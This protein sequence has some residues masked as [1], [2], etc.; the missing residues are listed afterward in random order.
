[1]TEHNQLCGNESVTLKFGNRFGMF[2]IDLRVS[3]L[4]WALCS[5]I[6]RSRSQRSTGTG[7]RQLPFAS[8]NIVLFGAYLSHLLG[9]HV[10]NIQHEIEPS[11]SSTYT[12]ADR[13]SQFVTCILG[14][15]SR[16][17][18][19]AICRQYPALYPKPST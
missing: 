7:M 5:A 15:I 19:I 4:G 2:E 13:T 3:S 9:C 14:I 18:H 1:M 8:I 17:K 16:L 10:S 11:F 12:S 6:N